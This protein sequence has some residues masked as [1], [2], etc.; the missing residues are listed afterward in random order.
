MTTTPKFTQSFRSFRNGGGGHA[1]VLVSEG[2]AAIEIEADYALGGYSLF[3][4]GDDD[5]VSNHRTVREARAAAI[6]AREID[7]A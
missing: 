1:L 2:F 6:A 5:R 3:R 4:E 7:Q